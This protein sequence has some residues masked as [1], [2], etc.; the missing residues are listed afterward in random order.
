MLKHAALLIVLSDICLFLILFNSIRILIICFSH[1]LPLAV[2]LQEQKH[3]CKVDPV[4][5]SLLKDTYYCQ[6]FL[7]HKDI[8]SC[9]EVVSARDCIYIM[10]ELLDRTV[11]Q[12]AVQ[13]TKQNC[14]INK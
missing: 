10:I 5:P 12:F 7:N 4:A 14:F 6:R 1:T 11:F 3:I 9:L 2:H 8:H 13:I